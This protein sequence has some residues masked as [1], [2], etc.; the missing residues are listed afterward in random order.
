VEI[1]DGGWN[2]FLRDIEMLSGSNCSAVGRE[3][4]LKVKIEGA[5]IPTA[6]LVSQ[7]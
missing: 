4:N 5:S 3:G 7:P 2:T 1:L 6:M